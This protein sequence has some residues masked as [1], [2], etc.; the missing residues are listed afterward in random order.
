[1]INSQR[2]K[3]LTLPGIDPSGIFNPWDIQPFPVTPN[4]QDIFTPWV[5]STLSSYSTLSRISSPLGHIQPFPVTP[6][7]QGYLQPFPV[8]C[9]SSGLSPSAAMPSVPPAPIFPM[10]TCPHMALSSAVPVSFMPPVGA[11]T[12]HPIPIDPYIA[13]PGG[14]RAR[15]YYLAGL[16]AYPAVNRTACRAG[17]DRCKQRYDQKFPFHNRCFK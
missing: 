16:R 7:L 1:M 14:C 12:P 11:T 15:I 9:I 4:L 2:L 3:I 13:V 6:N 8:Y 5:Y 17:K 10:A